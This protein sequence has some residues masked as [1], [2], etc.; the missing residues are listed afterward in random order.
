[1]IESYSKLVGLEN[2]YTERSDESIE[3]IEYDPF[4]SKR[5]TGVSKRY[6]PRLNVNS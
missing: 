6:N 5:M 4:K 3:K 2:S 1:L